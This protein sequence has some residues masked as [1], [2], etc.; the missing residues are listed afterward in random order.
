MDSEEVVLILGI[1]FPNQREDV[2]YEVGVPVFDRTF[3]LRAVSLDREPDVNL[4]G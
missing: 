3:C 2:K 1:L 4:P